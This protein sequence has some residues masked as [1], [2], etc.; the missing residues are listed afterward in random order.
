MSDKMPNHLYVIL[1]A[2]F[3]IKTLNIYIISGKTL[4]LGYGTRSMTK[5]KF[6]DNSSIK[7]KHVDM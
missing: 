3:S 2:E 4:R 1:V 7:S 5:H 6:R